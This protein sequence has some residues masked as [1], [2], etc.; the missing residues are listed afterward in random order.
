VFDDQ[1]KNIILND[2]PYDIL[3]KQKVK[4]YN[5]SSMMVMNTKNFIR[6]ILEYLETK[7]LIQFRKFSKK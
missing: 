1:N 4:N 7:K 5:K 2:I 6:N 3:I